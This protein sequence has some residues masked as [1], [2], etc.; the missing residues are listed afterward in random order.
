MPV[1]TTLKIASLIELPTG[2]QAPSVLIESLLIPL[3][4]SAP[5]AVTTDKVG[6]FVKFGRRYDFGAFCRSILSLAEAE[7][8]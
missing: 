3:E 5:S 2:D 4:L 8:S 1:A 6:P 7:R